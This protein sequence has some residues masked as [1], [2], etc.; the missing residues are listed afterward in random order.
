[1]RLRVA[2]AVCVPLAFLE[3]RV[4]RAT[5][6][7]SAQVGCIYG[8]VPDGVLRQRGTR[9]LAFC[10]QSASVCLPGALPAVSTPRGID[11]HALPP[12]QVLHIRAL[13][14]DS[15]EQAGLYCSTFDGTNLNRLFT[16]V[17]PLHFSAGTFHFAYFSRTT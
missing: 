14:G 7:P 5:S 8:C 15:D 16:V 1:M 11:G 9:H 12:A 13:E 10:S 4:A 3:R 17:T 2:I 6:L